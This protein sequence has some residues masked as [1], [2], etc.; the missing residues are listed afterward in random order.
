MIGLAGE[1][2]VMVGRRMT[3]MWRPYIHRGNARLHVYWLW[4]N[5]DLYGYVNREKDVI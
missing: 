2:E 1:F 5:I 4:W 3:F